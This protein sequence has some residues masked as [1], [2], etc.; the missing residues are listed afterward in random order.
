[1][2][3][4]HNASKFAGNHAEADGLAGFLVS[5][6]VVRSES[7]DVI[8]DPRF[9]QD[10]VINYRLAAF[11]SLS[12]VSGLLTQNTMTELF[13][14]NK[15]MQ[16]FTQSHRIYHPMGML[17]LSAFSVLIVILGM[18]MLSTYV[19][20]AQPY[21]T[22]RLMT[23]G[24]TGF[25]SAASYYLNQNIVVFRHAAIKSMLASLPLFI[26]QIALRIMVK[27]DRDNVQQPSAAPVTPFESHIQG[28]IFCVIM[29]LMSIALLFIHLKHFA[30]FRDRYDQMHSSVTGTQFTQYMQGMMTARKTVGLLD[31]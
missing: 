26:L 11:S 24:P 21:H 18:N 22:I 9:F 28:I 16:L 25:D 6:G 8:N 4:R 30:I 23:A 13:E 3:Q 5:S 29:A 15:D 7:M 1:M 20:V 2:T 10:N 12:V 31:V 17:Q 14:M 27:F 19:G